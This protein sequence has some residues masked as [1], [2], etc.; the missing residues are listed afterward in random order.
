MKLNHRQK[1]VAT[2]VLIV[3]LVIVMLALV[4]GSVRLRQW[5]ASG[6]SGQAADMFELQDG[7]RVLRPNFTTRT[8]SVNSLGFRGP[9]LTQPKPADTLRLAFVGASTTFSAE[10][11]GNN[12]TWPHLVTEAIQDR[13]PDVNVDYVNAAVPGYT[14]KLSLINFR[15]RVAPLHPDVT[16]VYHA[17]NDLSWETRSLATKQGIYEKYGEKNSN[18]LSRHSQLWYLVE[19]NL[20]IKEAKEDALKTVGRLE[21]SPSELG[22]HF[23]RDLTQLVIEAQGVSKLVALVTFSIQ[24]RPEQTAGQQLTAAGS[25][26]YYM[27][28]MDT[29]GLIAAFRRYN[30]I[31]AEVASETGAV[32]IEGETLIPGDTE[33]FNDSVHF[34]DAGSR[35]MANRVSEALLK[36]T[37]FQALAA[38]KRK[39]N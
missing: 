3:L 16:V 25:A 35:I 32:L 2:T 34:K 4:E 29:Q 37:E 6:Y 7:L 38:D 19:K 14:V 23:R 24:I 17:T 22:E 9:P 39:N 8:I 31:M 18:W 5:F 28:F 33:H 30:Q 15:R 12:M 27:P 26:L 1:I 36:S 21:F 10:V 13:Y 20:R 11:S